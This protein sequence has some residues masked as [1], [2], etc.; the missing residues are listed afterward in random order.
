M[1][2]RSPTDPGFGRFLR[3]SGRL[4]LARQ[5][6][7]LA[8]VGVVMLL[9]ALASRAIATDFAWAYF[10]ML[11]LS[12]LLGLGLERLAGTTVAGRGERTVASALG[13]LVGLRLLLAP[14]TFVALWLFFAFVDVGLPPV[15]WMATFVW[16]TAALLEPVLFGGL[17]AVGNSAAEP[18]V[19]LGVRLAQASSLAVLAA[20]GA[21]LS[22]LVGVVALIESAGVVAALVVVGPVR[23]LTARMCSWRELPLRRAIALAGI[24]VVGL[25]NLRLDLLLVGRILGAALGATYGLVYRAVDGF[26]GVVGSA[27]LWLYAESANERDGGTDP[28]GIRA[29]S[30]ALLPR[31]GVALGLVLVVGA[32]AVG[33]AVPRLGAQADTLRLLA[34]A[35]PLLTINAIELHVRSGRGRNREVLAI[36]AAT[37]AFNLPLCVMLIV[38]FGLPGAACALVLSELWQALL[39]G[40]TASRGERALMGPALLTATAGAVALVAT[41]RAI[42]ESNAVVAVLAGLLTITL[43]LVR[44]P[45]RARRAA[46]A[47]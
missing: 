21:P 20:M 18:T 45:R 43:V 35:F 24:E 32:G 41:G 6:S 16:T 17:R 1:I 26:Y 13:P 38:E 37:L 30:L 33:E 2:G 3:S 28:R 5:L 22:A 47:S 11:T 4:A 15:A 10:A 8:L 23:D 12:S 36:N 25:V 29:R 46:V 44:I 31:V 40:V 19:M 27:G 34:A 14:G 9:P 39:L 7:A 42:S